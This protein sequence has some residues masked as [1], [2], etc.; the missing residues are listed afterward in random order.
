VPTQPNPD[1]VL[2]P[3]TGKAEPLSHWLTTF[4]LLLA[5]L[6][7]FTYESAWLLETAARVLSTFAQADCRVGWL[8]TGDP[9]ECREF[10][11]PHGRRFL[12][13]SDPEREVVKTLGLE[14]LPALVDL[15]L[16]ATIID[17]AEGWHP[18]E[19][20]RVTEH[21]AT[22]LSWKGPHLPGPKDP[23]PFAGTA[24]LG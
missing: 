19:W 21:L 11:G 2:R 23:A 10:L 8:V 18:A 22:V 1:V 9:D 16:D 17:A 24:A 5:V 3:I 20:H 6:D 14:R 15:G 13:F 12:T 4:H 7:P